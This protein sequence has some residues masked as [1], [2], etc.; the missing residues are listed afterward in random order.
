MTVPT[1][2]SDLELLAFEGRHP[3]ANGHK[4][5]RIINELGIKPARFYQRLFRI[6][7]TPEALAADPLLTNRLR[8]QALALHETQHRRLTTP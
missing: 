7:W 8:R 5:D 1:P 3:K 2:P 6:I 4:D